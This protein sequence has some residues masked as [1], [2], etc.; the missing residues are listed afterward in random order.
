MIPNSATITWGERMKGL[1][2]KAEA[3]SFKKRWR[4]VNAAER[5]ELRIAPVAHKLRQLDALM[6]SVEGL[7][8][9]GA[10][11]AEESEVRDRWNRL[12]KIYHV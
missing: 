8:W 3:R 12:R 4:A 11:T 10:L 5:E 7:G 2:T 9:T 1:I 6:A